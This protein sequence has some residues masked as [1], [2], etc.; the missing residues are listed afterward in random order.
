MIYQLL[1]NAGRQQAK[2][3]YSFIRYVKGL[4]KIIHDSDEP[5]Q[6]RILALHELGLADNKIDNNPTVDDYFNRLSE[7]RIAQAVYLEDDQYQNLEES[8]RMCDHYLEV[9]ARLISPSALDVKEEK[10]ED[11]KNKETLMDLVR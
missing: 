8:I 10:E 5:L 2:D 7:E 9:I 1:I 4:L 6:N 11:T 3:H